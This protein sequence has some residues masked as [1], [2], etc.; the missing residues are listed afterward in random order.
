MYVYNKEGSD[1]KGAKMD[2]WG[3]HVYGSGI[4]KGAGRLF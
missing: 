1:R 3:E 2:D 4:K